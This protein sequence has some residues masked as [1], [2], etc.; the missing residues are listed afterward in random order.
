[1]TNFEKVK[2]M[3]PEELAKFIDEL[4]THCNGNECEGCPICEGICC[5]NIEIEYWL[6][7]EVKE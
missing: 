5:C 2:N 7:K 3:S 6:N 1:M 4:T